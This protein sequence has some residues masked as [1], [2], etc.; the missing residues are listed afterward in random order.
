MDATKQKLKFPILTLAYLIMM[1]VGFFQCGVVSGLTGNPAL[2]KELKDTQALALL[3]LLKPGEIQYINENTP[4]I[5]NPS[6]NTGTDPNSVAPLTPP[7]EPLKN[8]WATLSNLPRSFTNSTSQTIGDKIYIFGS[9]VYGNLTDGNAYSYNTV[10]AQWN[11][12]KNM[13]AP[14][15]GSSSAVIGSKIYIFGGLEYVYQMTNDPAPYCINQLL[16]HCFEW[17]DPPPQYAYISQTRNSVYIY[18]TATDTWNIG[19]SMLVASGYHSSIAHDGKIYIFRNGNVE[20]YDPATNQWN[21]I[22]TNSPIF[23]YYSVQGYNGK[24]YFFGGTTN[25]NGN[26]NNVFEFDP[27]TLTFTQKTNM[28]TNRTHVVTALVGDKIYVMGGV[29]VIEEFT[30]ETNSWTVKA[31]LPETAY[32]AM[33]VG[34]Y[35]N[36]R[37][38]GIGGYGNVVVYYDPANDTTTHLKVLMGQ[39]RH[40]FASAIYNNKFYVFGGH[41][42]SSTLNWIEVLDL[43]SNS[44]SKI[45]ELPNGRHGFKAAVLGN[46]I[47]LV[48]GNRGS[49]TLTEVEIFDPETG[50]ITTG[51]PMDTPRSYL[52][53]CVNNGKMYAVGG[54]NGSTILNTIEEFDPT[55]NE[56][57]YKRTMTTARTETACTFHEN[58]LFVFGGR[59]GGSNYTN[60]VESYN[61]ASDSWSLHS[62]MNSARSLFDV[63]KLRGRIYAVGGWN[64][65]SM[66]Q[67]EKYDPLLEQWIPEYPMNSA[68]YGLSAI[69]PD[70]NR[71]IVVGGH[72]G[73]GSLNS[74]EEFY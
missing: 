42:G 33:G 35:A 56:W 9:N 49:S 19:A 21:R 36:N 20:V 64:G 1:A 26:V 4:P 5:D 39:A 8:I 31:S 71:I 48:G 61:P 43:V 59:L 63:V 55:T 54:N 34:G 69:A 38:Y 30:P 6:N 44:W 68:R 66:A 16:W 46:K 12:L 73:N 72:N 70:P 27:T 50:S 15:F 7:P 14:R 52:S 58:K 28:P 10:T 24:F 53:L 17:Y 47:Y 41:N 22:L 11:K 2:E 32:L 37:F 25:I 51:T 74:A 65:G 67:V 57:K 45:G 62:P 40:Y 29:R 60:S 3:G 13:P 23:S 18:D